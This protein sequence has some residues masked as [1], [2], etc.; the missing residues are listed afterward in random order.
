M[1]TSDD[2]NTIHLSLG[3][4]QAWTSSVYGLQVGQSG[5]E[6]IWLGM[7]SGKADLTYTSSGKYVFRLGGVAN[8]IADWNFNNEAIYKDSNGISLSLGTAQGWTSSVYGLNIGTSVSNRMYM[9]SYS[10][11][12]EFAYQENGNYIFRL[13]SA[14]NRI[15]AWDFDYYSIWSGEKLYGSGAGVEMSNS[16]KMFSAHLNSTNYTRLFYSSSSNWG[17]EGKY[18][19]DTFF[20]LGSENH[21]ANWNFDSTSIYHTYS[22]YRHIILSNSESES[23]TRGKRGFTIYND[24]AYVGTYGFKIAR[25]G[26]ITKKDTTQDWTSNGTEYGIQVGYLF[27]G[28]GYKDVFRIGQNEANIGS[29]NIGWYSL[30]STNLELINYDTDFVTGQG[31]KAIINLYQTSG[32]SDWYNQSSINFYDLSAIDDNHILRGKVTGG[33]LPIETGGAGYIANARISTA[34]DTAEVIAAD[35]GAGNYGRVILRADT[36]T[37]IIINGVVVMEVYQGSNGHTQFKMDLPSASYADS[38]C[39]YNNGAANS[40]VYVK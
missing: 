16:P 11:N 12:M 15:G 17:V 4:A 8:Q 26:M 28:D 27:E 9:G 2:T 37:K 34:N 31:N 10:G 6:R 25:F 19:G 1:Y 35:D 21:I 23:S 5:S 13:G 18:G 22:S 20:R 7:N 38:G 33:Y 29:F 30:R 3:Y 32:V 39:L 24:D 14:A 36:A 40:P